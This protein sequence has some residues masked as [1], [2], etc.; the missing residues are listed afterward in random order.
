MQHHYSEFEK[1]QSKFNLKKSIEKTGSPTKTGCEDK[2]WK[3][4]AK[5]LQ[6]CVRRLSLFG[7]KLRIL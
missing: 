6:L 4:S 5:H 1:R 3:G 2:F 7:N